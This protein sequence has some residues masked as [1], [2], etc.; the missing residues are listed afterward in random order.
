MIQIKNLSLHY[1]SG[2]TLQPLSLDLASEQTHVFLGSSGSGKTTVLK[3]ILGLEQ[4]SSGSIQIFDKE[5]NST[6]QREIAKL[7]GYVP[8]EGGL[9][10]HLTNGQNVGL[11]GRLIDMDPSQ[12]S[13]RLKALTELVGFS[14]EALDRFPS[15]ISGGQRQRVALMRAL[16]TDPAIIVLDEPLGALDPLIRSKL[17]DDLKN[18]FNQLKKMVLIV[19][20]DLS[21]AAFFGHTVSLFHEGSLLQ[22]SS[23]EDMVKNPKV[24]FVTEFLKAHRTF[25]ALEILRSPSR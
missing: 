10:P 19:T 3:L 25:D 12:F 5:V 23:I 20:H 2:F 22:H 4:F 8:Q 7:V 16:F 14:P 18:I 11:P 17:Q 6:N 9:F 1:K 21:E 24:P 13:K 15:E